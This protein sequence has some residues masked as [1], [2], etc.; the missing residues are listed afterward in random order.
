MMNKAIR[1]LCGVIL[2][3]GFVFPAHATPVYIDNFAVRGSGGVNFNDDFNDGNPPVDGPS[4]EY[5]VTG[6]LGPESG[7]KLAMLDSGLQPVPSPFG[8]NL[9]FQG[10]MLKT[11]R[12][13]NNDVDGLKIGT[14]FMMQAIFDLTEPM[15][16][17]EGYG[18]RFTDRALGIGK[19][20][21]DILEIAVIRTLADELIISLREINN[22]AKTI[23]VLDS[24]VLDMSFSQIGLGLSWDPKDGLMAAYNYDGG[25]YQFLS[26]GSAALFEG[27]NWTR[28]QFFHRSRAKVPEPSTLLLI[29]SVLLISGGFKRLKS[30]TA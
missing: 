13:S 10:G 26:T 18:I 11:N 24:I 9:L 23:D 29:S 3:F 25:G 2:V 8:D 28:A 4:S 27:E 20:G 5:F 15:T 30:K 16:L 1:A 6:V 7:G 22:V 19:V 21:S 14:S 12:N 17:G